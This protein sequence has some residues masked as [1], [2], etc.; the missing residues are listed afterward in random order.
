V[1]PLLFD[2]QTCV[3]HLFGGLPDQSVI[4]LNKRVEKIEHT[5]NGVRALLTDGTM[6]EG[7]I[8]I[9]ADGVHSIVRSQMWYYASA[10]EPETV[11][12]S[13]KSALFSEYDALFGVSK[14][15]GSHE[16][17][18]MAAA[19]TNIVFG[20]GVTKL[21]FQQQGQQLWAIIFKDRYCQPPKK[22]KATDQDMEDVAQRFSDIALNEKVNF[23]QL[24]ESRTRAGLL[25]L[26]EG[27][28]SQWHAGR[29][30][31]V[32]DSAHK[33]GYNAYME[34]FDRTLNLSVDLANGSVQMTA[35]LGAGANIAIEDAVVLCNIL[36]RELEKDRNRHPSKAQITSILA[37]YQKERFSRAKLFTELSGKV[38]RAHSY[39]TL[40]GK[41]LAT[42]IGPMMYETQLLK[43]ATEWAKA[44]KLDYVPVRTIDENAPGWLLVRGEEKSLS[45]SWLMCACFGAVV[46]GLVFARYRLS[47]L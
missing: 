28:L 11:P 12:E 38:T 34:L 8:V 46:T 44:P 10:S 27:V 15:E 29:I 23:R 2:R 32:G 30:V 31:L 35:D 9:G 25:T 33:V 24:W 6:E 43:L 7:D 3:A 45:R 41:L 22:F 37:E 18:G 20:Q 19:E 17:Y 47:R 5:E 42:R 21:F 13:D 1:P 4:K 40:I 39:D 36:H 14:L 16:D 26:E